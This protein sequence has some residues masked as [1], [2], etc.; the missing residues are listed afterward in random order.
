MASGRLRRAFARM[1]RTR[2]GLLP[3]ARCAAGCGRCLDGGLA[4][5]AVCSWPR[6]LVFS[7]SGVRFGL[8]WLVR[9]VTDGGETIA[10]AGGQ[11]FVQLA[12]GLAAMAIEILFFAR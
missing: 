3:A 5:R 11:K 10:Q 9:F 6:V 12:E 2:L 7:A 8:C 1:A 4:R